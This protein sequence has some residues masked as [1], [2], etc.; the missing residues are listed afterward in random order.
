MPVGFIE[1]TDMGWLGKLV[2]GTIGFAL[3]GPLGAVAGA[4]FGHVFD[5]GKN[6]EYTQ[7]RQRLS[8]G[9]QAQLTFF[10]AAFSMLAKMVK[11]DGRISQEEIASIERFMVYDLGLDPQSRMFAMN[12]FNSALNSPGSFEEFAQQFYNQFQHQPQMLEL[13]LDIL[14]RVAMADGGLT[15]GEEKLIQS[16]TRIFRFSDTHFGNVKTRH[17]ADTNKY[18][19][20][21]E[22]TPTDS[23]EQIKSRYRKLVREFHPDTI[24]SK[25]LPEE[26]TKFAE[27]K[28]REIQEAYDAIKKE[29]GLS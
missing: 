28:F 27:Q 18:Y 6:V 14:T 19:A 5:A 20:V 3:G 29:R 22:S 11:A 24:A 2:G 21:L 12:L 26:F 9:E 13:M 8:G 17:T 16:A 23:D 15:R 25:G 4:A 1:R 10:V 7:A